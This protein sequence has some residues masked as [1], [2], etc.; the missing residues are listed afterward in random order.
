MLVFRKT[1]EAAVEAQ[2]EIGAKAVF[3]LAKSYGDALNRVT[4]LQQQMAAWVL[5]KPEFI[6]AEQAAQMFYAQD[7]RWQAAFFNGMQD[8]VRAYHDALPPARHRYEHVPSA[9]IP[10]GEGQWYHMAQHLTD[11]GFET[12]EAMFDHAKH[13]RES[14]QSSDAEAA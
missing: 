13:H 14:Q 2:R 5:N 10:A 9:G 11:E 3:N 1:M 8:Q 7:D 6:S 4:A 12:I